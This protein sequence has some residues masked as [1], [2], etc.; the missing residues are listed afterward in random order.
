MRPEVF[1]ALVDAG[2]VPHPSRISKGGRLFAPGHAS[3]V[4]DASSE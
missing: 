1:L 4:D 3:P 2:S